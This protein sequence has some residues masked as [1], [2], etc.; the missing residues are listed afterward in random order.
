MLGGGDDDKGDDFRMTSQGG[1]QAGVPQTTQKRLSIQ[2]QDASSS[3]HSDEEESYMDT[4][5]SEMML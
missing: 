4:Q 3:E 5:R 2:I 1:F